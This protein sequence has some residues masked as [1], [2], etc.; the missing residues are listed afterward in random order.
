MS[1][2]HAYDRPVGI[3]ML[4]TRFPRLPGDVG[5]PASFDCP[6]L[7]ETLAG[8]GP[9]MAVRDAASTPGLVDVLVAAAGRLV[10]RGATVIST[11]CGFL[12]LFQRELA[13]RCAVPVATSSL[14]L[15]PRIEAAL[16]SGRRVGVL[17][18]EARSLTAAHFSACDAALDTPFEGMA[19][20]GAFARTFLDNSPAIDAA[21][22]ERETVEAA[23]RLRA[24]HPDLGAIV[25]ECTNLPPYAGAVRAACGLPVYDIRDAIAAARPNP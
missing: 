21:A 5:N 4:D 2:S 16:P 18:A 1:G 8:V 24:R 23:R 14:L 7:Y 10:A 20:N 25:L 12:A 9:Q 11:S 6:V 13:G 17:T 19:P 22:V 15:I 3:L